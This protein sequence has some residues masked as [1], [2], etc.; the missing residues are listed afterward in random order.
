MFPTSRFRLIASTGAYPKV[1]E[2]VGAVIDLVAKRLRAGHDEVKGNGSRLSP[3]AGRL[4]KRAV[5]R[6]VRLSAGVARLPRGQAGADH[7]NPMRISRAL[8]ATPV[9]CQGGLT[10]ALGPGW[11]VPSLSVAPQRWAAG[12]VANPKTSTRSIATT[13]PMG[14]RGRDARM[15]RS[16]DLS[17]NRTRHSSR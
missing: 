12:D 4:R 11:H 15:S 13:Y 8:K 5:A 7:H 10:A 1:R 2:A 3:G 9:P 14:G 16:R 17:I 6:R